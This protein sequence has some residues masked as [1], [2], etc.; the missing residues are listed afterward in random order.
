MSE[1]KQ[2][3]TEPGRT[4]TEAESGAESQRF[5]QEESRQPSDAEGDR[6]TVEASLRQ[7][8]A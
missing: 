6:E 2:Q 8:E 5:P 4:A 1:E 3:A 7:K